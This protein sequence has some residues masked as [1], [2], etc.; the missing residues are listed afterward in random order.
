M[1]KPHLVGIVVLVMA[2][3]CRAQIRLDEET[4]VVFAT[5]EQG[6]QVLTARDE[7]VRN[8]SPFD[9]AA[10]MK[11]NHEVSEEAFLEF[12]GQNVLAWTDAEQKRIESLFAEI[13]PRTAA[14]SL[15]F[16]P[17]IYLIKTGGREEGGAAY[18]RANAVVVPATMLGPNR[19]L[20]ANLICHELFHVLTRANPELR[21]RLYE[22]I[23]FKKCNEIELPAALRPR[24]L[25]NPDAP[26][27]EHYIEVQVEGQPALAVPVLFS[28]SERYDPNRGGEFFQYLVFQFLL[29]ERQADS[30]NLS[31]IYRDGT[32]RLVE[33]DQLS[34][35]WEQVGRNTQYIFHPEEI[36]ADNFA[37][38][39]RQNGR[40]RSPEILGS[41]KGVLLAWPSDGTGDAGGIP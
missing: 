14:F 30:P 19:M 23:G 28:R 21:D 24:K 13:Q 34:G 39:V 27:N 38:L 18:T 20:N 3:W 5:V 31:V 16:P 17:T 35:F 40:I 29:V 25:T 12:V 9:R 8:L 33:A 11:T 22:V 15:P 6:R 26:T 37:L 7:F 32:P 4:T 2:G 36:L 41:L 1:S 10:R